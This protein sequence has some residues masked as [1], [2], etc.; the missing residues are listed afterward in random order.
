MAVEAGQSLQASLGFRCR[1]IRCD[2]AT[3]QDQLSLFRESYSVFGNTHVVIANAAVVDYA[4]CFANG[5]DDDIDSEPPLREV[6]I[7]LRGV[8][9]TARIGLHYLRKAGGGDL[10]MTSSIGGFKETAHL[11]PYLASKH[12]VIGVLRGLRMSTLAD[13]IRVNVVCP[14]MT[15]E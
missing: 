3:Y 13:G 6:D 15:S 1:F 8:M 2:T 5:D 4:D 11:T 7:N 10:I 12:G 9:F 14:W